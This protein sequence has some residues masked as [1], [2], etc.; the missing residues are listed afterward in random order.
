MNSREPIVG[1]NNGFL[2]KIKLFSGIALCLKPEKD[3]SILE[4]CP[5]IEGKLDLEKSE[6]ICF[7]ST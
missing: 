5:S 6:S 4:G 7:L 2:A 3:L 1:L